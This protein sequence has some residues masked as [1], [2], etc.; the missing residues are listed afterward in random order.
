M[1]ANPE[2][3]PGL[4]SPA[5]LHPAF[6]PPPAN[7]TLGYTERSRRAGLSTKGYERVPHP[8]FIRRVFFR[9]AAKTGLFTTENTEGTEEVKD[10]I[11]S[12]FW[13]ERRF[14]GAASARE[15]KPAS[16]FAEKLETRKVLAK[17]SRLNSI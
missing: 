5:L 9:L 14:S 6:R 11:V 17:I 3:L 8:G 10:L 13:V 4:S 1:F 12:V 16:Q 2:P 15:G 7:Y